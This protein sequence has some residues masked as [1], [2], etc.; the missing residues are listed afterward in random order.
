MN[1]KEGTN[2]EARSPD[3]NPLDFFF[4]GYLKDRV[5]KTKSQNLDNL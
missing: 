2:R 4:W 3:M 5:Y 1:R